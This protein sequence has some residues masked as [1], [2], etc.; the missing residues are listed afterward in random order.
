MLAPHHSV[1]V[2]KFNFK[3]KDA[4]GLLI[5][6]WG[7]FLNFSRVK[8]W[9]NIEKETVTVVWT[10]LC[11]CALCQIDLVRGVSYSFGACLELFSCFQKIHIEK[12]LIVIDIL[13]KGGNSF[14]TCNYQKVVCFWNNTNSIISMTNNNDNKRPFWWVQ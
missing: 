14:L 12:A 7:V 8:C 5:T 1:P 4:L 11:P 3:G 2:S 10:I 6:K 9:E 13:V